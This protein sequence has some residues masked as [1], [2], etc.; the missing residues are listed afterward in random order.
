MFELVF[1]VVMLWP[2]S[3]ATVNETILSKHI[4]MEDCLT[5]RQ[6]VM[7]KLSNDPPKTPSYLDCRKTK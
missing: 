2:G 6:Q 7:I 1:T 4:T 5:M 3:M